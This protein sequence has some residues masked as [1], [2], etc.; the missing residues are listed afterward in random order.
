MS[1]KVQRLKLRL[2]IEGVEIPCISAVVQSQPNSPTTASIQIPPLSEATRFLPRSLVHLYFLDFYDEDNG[3][4]RKSGGS[5]VTA[6]GPSVHEQSLVTEGNQK[7]KLLFVGDLMGFSWTKNALNRSVVLQ[8]ADP[9]NYWDYAW[10]YSNTDIFGPGI[11]AMFS[12]GSTNKFTD[13]LASPSEIMTQVIHT[14]SQRY[15][16]LRG[17]L[18]GIIHLLETMGGYYYGDKKIGGQNI[19]YTLAELRLHITQMI[20]AYDKDPTAKKLLGGGYDALF[21]RTIGNLGDQASFRKIANALASSIFHESYGQPCPRY[22]PGLGGT[23][24]G[25]ERKKLQDLRGGDGYNFAVL[26]QQALDLA[27]SLSM[28][29][30]YL[31]DYSTNAPPAEDVDAR[32]AHREKYKGDLLQSFVNV[33]NIS[34]GAASRAQALARDQFKD[35]GSACAKLFRTAAT[36]CGKAIAQL[37]KEF[38]GSTSTKSGTA[39]SDSLYAAANALRKIPTLETNIT[40]ASE[41]IPAQLRQQIFRPDVWFSAPPRCNV[42]FPDQYHS[43][44]YARSFMQETTRLMLKTNDEFFGEDELFDHFY[45][46]PKAVTLKAEKNTLQAILKGDIMDHELFTGILPVF[47]KMGEFNIFAA[48]SGRVDGKTPKVGL[49]QRSTNFLYFK[50]RFA[51]RQLQV[52]GKFNPYIAV[53]FPGLIIDKYIDLET[54]RLH[55]ELLKSVPNPHGM[56]SPKTLELL[57][58]HFLGSFTEVT[59]QIDQGQGTTMINC[60]YARQPEEKTEFLG[61]L[62]Q[63]VS[64][65]KKTGKV[66]LRETVV[67]SIYAP[68]V[69]SQGPGFGNII[70]VEEVTQSNIGEGKLLPLFGSKRDKKTKQ[71]SINVP[72]G[73]TALAEDFGD[74]VAEF[75]GDPLIIVTFRAWKVTEEVAQTKTERVELPPEEYIRPGW[76]GDCW[77]PSKISEVYYDFFNTGAITEPQQVHNSD[78]NPKHPGVTNSDASSAL[79]DMNNP[80]KDPLDVARDQL[81]ALSLTKDSS[82]QQAVAY[83]VLTYSVIRQAGFDSEQFIRSY[84]WRPIASMPDM[85]GSSDLQLAPD[86]KDVVRGVEG[87]HSRAFGPYEDLFGLVTPDVESVV[88]I[89]R[90]SPQAQRADTRMRKYNAVLDYV[91]QLRLSRALIG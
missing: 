32:T 46:A 50:Y 82:I 27:N 44:N 48:R 41:A 15:P 67:A 22:T 56:P 78:G 8:C 64:V 74:A 72:V 68:R 36:E 12:G 57:G 91:A 40:K 49:A 63:E 34:S 89:K 87:F 51:A 24:S 77:H 31:N 6:P 66:G 20:T 61:S 18:G 83:L 65:A 69:N 11:K 39:M 90:G 53:G 42:I 60:S 84:T 28:T 21:G 16:G 73:V 85:F 33:K 23:V 29:A 52:T 88:G 71:L 81:I 62:Q 1:A 86:G 17:L 37:K 58:T 26:A 75:V 59:H 70:R 13:I 76:Y 4:V 5:V 14:P 79:A 45:F 25:F 9:S 43:L 19:F 80:D 7:Y 2:F 35:V 3:G 10:Q 55:N 38:T 47:E 30:E 54:L